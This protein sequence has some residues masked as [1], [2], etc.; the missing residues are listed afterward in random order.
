MK[1]YSYICIW[2]YS[3]NLNVCIQIQTKVALQIVFVFG[4]TLL[5][6]QYLYS[7]LAIFLNP[8]SIRICVLSN[9]WNWLVFVSIFGPEITICS[10]LSWCSMNIFELY[11]AH[12]DPGIRLGYILVAILWN[13]PKFLSQIQENIISEVDPVRL[14]YI[15]VGCQ[16]TLSSPNINIINSP[17][18]LCHISM[19]MMIVKVMVKKSVTFFTWLTQ[20][21]REVCLFLWNCVA[22]H[23]LLQT[24]SIMGKLNLTLGP[25]PK[26]IILSCYNGRHLPK[27][28]H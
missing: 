20:I 23:F 18:P 4:Q 11:C 3:N 5:P 16:Q 12:F 27:N 19:M 10:P 2:Y 14:D 8:N 25:R 21:L 17:N 15:G 13:H 22:S 28:C 9:F 26:F 6:V 24:A 1:Y 7:Y